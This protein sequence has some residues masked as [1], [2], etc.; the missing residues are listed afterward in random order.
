MTLQTPPSMTQL[1][2]IDEISRL[3]GSIDSRLE[4]LISKDRAQDERFEKVDAKF[5]QTAETIRQMQG[6]INRA[7]GV[8][9][10]VA[11]VVPVALEVIIIDQLNQPAEA[12]TEVRFE[13]P[14]QGLA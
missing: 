10:V 3:L 4:A 6:F 2:Q 11:I 14:N 13:D 7:I 9:A 12:G 1:P 5:E 8:L